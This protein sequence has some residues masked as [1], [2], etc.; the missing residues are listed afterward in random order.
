MSVSIII[1]SLLPTEALGDGGHTARGLQDLKADI[2]LRVPALLLTIFAQCW[3]LHLCACAGYLRWI[4]GND[5]GCGVS[6]YGWLFHCRAFVCIQWCVWKR[7]HY[8]FINRV[9]GSVYVT[10]Q[11]IVFWLGGRDFCGWCRRLC[12][13][14][15]HPLAEW[16]LRGSCGFRMHHFY[17]TV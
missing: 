17:F 8:T 5:F 4:S 16:Q 2:C 15:P 1:P 12:N 10:G 11:Q 7:W 6:T 13:I 14:H 3:R 9:Y